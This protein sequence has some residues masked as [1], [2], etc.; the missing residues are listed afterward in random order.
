MNAQPLAQACSG[1]LQAKLIPVRAFPVKSLQLAS[2][3]LFVAIFG[4]PYTSAGAL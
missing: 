1:S 2:P 4:D 3:S